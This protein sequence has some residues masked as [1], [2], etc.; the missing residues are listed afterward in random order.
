MD[1]EAK[2]TSS[3]VSRMCFANLTAVQ[4]VHLTETSMGKL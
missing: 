2:S 1:N 3:A 4:L